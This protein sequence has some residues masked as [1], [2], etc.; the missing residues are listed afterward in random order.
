MTKFNFF[1]AKKGSPSGPH[2][3]PAGAAADP[4]AGNTP[5]SGEFQEIGGV[6]STPRGTLRVLTRQ[7]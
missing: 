2:G 3:R 7:L 5:N 4:G 6:S 1:G